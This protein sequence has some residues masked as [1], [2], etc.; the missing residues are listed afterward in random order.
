MRRTLETKCIC[1]GFRVRLFEW[2]MEVE[3]DE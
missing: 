1:P 3:N 2:A